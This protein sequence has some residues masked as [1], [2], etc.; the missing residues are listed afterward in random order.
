MLVELTPQGWLDARQAA[1]LRHDTLVALNRGCAAIIISGMDLRYRDV[2]GLAG[3][4]ALL[5]EA[6]GHSPAV[7]IWLCHISPDLQAAAAL[8]ALSDAWSLAPDR[9]TALDNILHGE[10]QAFPATIASS[11][12]LEAVHV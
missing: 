11:S 12:P 9:A 2:A 4:A 6:R 8:A 10:R 3:L 1:R 5:A 7:P